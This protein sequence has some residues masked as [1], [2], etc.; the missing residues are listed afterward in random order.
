MTG[1]RSKAAE[2]YGSSANTTFRDAIRLSVDTSSGFETLLMPLMPSSDL[3]AA[4]T[5]AGR[6]GPSL[7]STSTLVGSRLPADNVEFSSA[8][9]PSTDSVAFL[10]KLVVE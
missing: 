8:L 2:V 5:S 6:T 3:L 4:A 7:R 10:K 1:T 9:K